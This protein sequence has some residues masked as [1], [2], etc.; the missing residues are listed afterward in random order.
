[1]V[2]KCKFIS[3]TLSPR[4][5]TYTTQVICKTFQ[6]LAEPGRAI[7]KDLVPKLLHRFSSNEGYTLAPGIDSLLRTLKQQS[8]TTNDQP[9][10]IVG[11]ITNSDD[12]VPGILSS[13]GLRVSPLRFGSNMDTPSKPIGTQQLDID[14]HCMSYDVGFAKP[15]RRIFDAAEAMAKN[16]IATQDGAY[17]GQDSGGAKADESWLKLYVGDEFEKDAKAACAAG[18]NSVLVGSGVDI[19]GQESLLDL[20]QCR[21]SALDR[22]FQQESSPLMIRAESTQAL[23]EWLI[24]QYVESG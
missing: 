22:V 19:G 4:L 6:P 12:R 10:V 23:L 20:E 2:G 8:N 15:D 13:L 14:F 24:K 7:P 11:V 9:Q 3:P 16:L 21:T 17:S 18:W 5:N 1:M